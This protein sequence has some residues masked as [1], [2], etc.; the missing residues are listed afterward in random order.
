MKLIK[1]VLFY[2]LTSIMFFSIPTD[3]VS[4]KQKYF[5]ADSLLETVVA[6]DNS[7]GILIY[8]DEHTAIVITSFHVIESHLKD[9]TPIGVFVPEINSEEPSFY[10]PNI[11]NLAIDAEN[12][13]ALLKINTTHKLKYSLIHLGGVRVGDDIFIASNPNFNFRSLKK[14]IISSKNRLFMGNTWEISGGVIYGSSGGGVFNSK[15]KLIGIVKG[16]DLHFANCEMKYGKI[17]KCVKVPLTDIGMI[18]PT[19]YVKKFII[20]S[21]F[22]DYFK[23]LRSK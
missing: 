11:E 23:Y 5:R 7:S 18:V 21:R 17:A 13:L 1:N 4:K 8:S 10:E 15:G 2:L 6:V 16:V 12:D 3:A 9:K 22:K 20:N 14:G 19:K